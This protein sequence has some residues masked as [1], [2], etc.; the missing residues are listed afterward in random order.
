[1]GGC[2]G[3]L[4]GDLICGKGGFLAIYGYLAEYAARVKVPYMSGL[5]DQTRKEAP[6]GEARRVIEGRPGPFSS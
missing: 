5:V 6:K 3:F 2:R 4:H 1:M